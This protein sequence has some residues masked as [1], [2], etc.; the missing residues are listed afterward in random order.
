MNIP[1]YNNKTI[2]RDGVLNVDMIT[3]LIDNLT[4]MKLK[5][6][7]I[8]MDQIGEKNN[9]YIV[10]I[11]LNKLPLI[12][13]TTPNLDNILNDNKL[14]LKLS[15]QMQVLRYLKENK[16]ELD[17]IFNDSQKQLIKDHGLNDKMIYVGVDLQ[18][19]T[20]EK[21]EAKIIN[22]KIKNSSSNSISKILKKISEGKK[23][24]NLEI[25]KYDYYE[26][27]KNYNQYFIKDE[28]YNIG[29]R[30]NEIKLINVINKINLINI[31]KPIEHNELIIDSKIE[32]KT[33]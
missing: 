8:N 26:R 12:N 28:M 4:Y 23:L 7:N 31:D 33:R 22:F 29:K 3:V 25:F 18:S 16:N 2:I 17:N 11:N 13:K 10:N 15:S 9:G 19:E 1:T 30:I 14:L 6:Y 5:H 24:N 20:S 21:Y 32:T 27:T